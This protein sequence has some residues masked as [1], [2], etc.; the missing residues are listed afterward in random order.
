LIVPYRAL[1]CALR[2]RFDFSLFSGPEIDIFLLFSSTTSTLSFLPVVLSTRLFV[3]SSFSFEQSRSMMLSWV[4][5]DL[6]T[7]GYLNWLCSYRFCGL[8]ASHWDIG[9]D[10]VVEAPL[11]T[12]IK[13]EDILQ[14]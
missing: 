11:S 3:F 8:L 12:T 14:L 5:L 10:T 13:Q 7:S 1:Q 9:L 6:N 4:H 2:I